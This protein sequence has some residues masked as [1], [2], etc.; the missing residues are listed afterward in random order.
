MIPKV[1]SNLSHSRDSIVSVHLIHNMYSFLSNGDNNLQM[2]L[3]MCQPPVPANKD[4]DSL[5]S[6]VLAYL[7]YCF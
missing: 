4:S 1:D 5:S 2:V 6:H 3:C 7:I